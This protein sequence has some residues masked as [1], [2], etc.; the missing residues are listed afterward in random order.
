MIQ[1][2][3]EKDYELTAFPSFHLFLV[4]PL[5][6]ADEDFIGIQRPKMFFF[7]TLFSSLPRPSLLS[8]LVLSHLW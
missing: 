4:L 8:S 2:R 7:F 5:N 6:Q 3:I 1:F